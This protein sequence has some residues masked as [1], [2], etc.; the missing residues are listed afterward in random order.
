MTSID[1]HKL[2]ASLA[3]VIDSPRGR[4]AASGDA[5]GTPTAAAASAAA[6][7]EAASGS[8]SARGPRQPTRIAGKQPLSLP[9]AGRLSPP[10]LHRP[11]IGWNGDVPAPRLTFDSPSER[12]SR[13][14]VRGGSAWAKGSP[15][16][17]AVGGGFAPGTLLSPRVH[18]PVPPP[19]PN[20]RGGA[21]AAEVPIAQRLTM[22][23]RAA[24]E[25][26]AR[27]GAAGGRYSNSARVLVRPVH[28]ESAREQAISGAVPAKPRSRQ[29]RQDYVAVSGDWSAPSSAK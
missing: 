10:G 8:V 17:S 6:G 13:N 1:V 15:R 24:R 5:L 4:A 29:F 26:A 18:R 23:Q 21:A 28:A 16:Q 12:R 3:R 2:A 25:L 19:N 9:V 20:G 7:A 11:P 27:R 14:D 22:R